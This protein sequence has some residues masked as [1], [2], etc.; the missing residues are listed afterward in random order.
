MSILISQLKVQGS[1]IWFTIYL[2]SVAATLMS[3]LIIKSPMYPWV[4]EPFCSFC[5][6]VMSRKS[7]GNKTS[8]P[9]IISTV[10]PYWNLLSHIL[11]YTFHMIFF[12]SVFCYLKISSTALSA[13]TK[14]RL[15]PLWCILKKGFSFLHLCFVN[16]SLH[17]Q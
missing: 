4:Q 5:T 9:S 8:F 13:T 14:Y 15:F 1:L 6:N 12:I 7:W 16:I 11:R 10:I 17:V 3:A 2:G